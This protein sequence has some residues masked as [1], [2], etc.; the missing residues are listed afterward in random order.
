MRRYGYLDGSEL[1]GKTCDYGV[2]VIGDDG[3]A[4]GDY[5]P[6]GKAA[7]YRAIGAD[8]FYCAE[9]A[10]EVAALDEEVYDDT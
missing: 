9:H 5:R 7:V 3:F 2:P 4:T 10:P 6:C 8:L 1:A